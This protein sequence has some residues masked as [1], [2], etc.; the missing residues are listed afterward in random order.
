MT[1]D[2]FKT[3]KTLVRGGNKFLV[4]NDYI[5]VAKVENESS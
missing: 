4:L 1:D 3:K 5:L 2:F